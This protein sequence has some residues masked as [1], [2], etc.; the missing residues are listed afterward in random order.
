MDSINLLKFYKYYKSSSFYGYSTTHRLEIILFISI[1][2]P[3][4]KRIYSAKATSVYINCFKHVTLENFALACYFFRTELNIIRGQ[5]ALIQAFFYK[6]HTSRLQYIIIRVIVASYKHDSKSLAE[7]EKKS[8]SR[9]DAYELCSNFNTSINML[10]QLSAKKSSERTSL[11][12][13]YTL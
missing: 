10:M 2:W 13:N 7:D 1:R 12:D 4:A 9:N 11:V 5:E 3:L 6:Q 8:F